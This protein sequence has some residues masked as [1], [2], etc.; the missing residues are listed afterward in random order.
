MKLKIVMLLSRI[1]QTGMTTHTLDLTKGLVQEGNEVFVISG[2]SPI[3]N[4][5]EL[6]KL[7]DRFFGSGAKI[8]EFKIPEG[9]LF[10]KSLN[11]ILSI[12]YIQLQL[13]KINPHIIHV[14]SPYM[15]FIPWFLNKKFLS[16]L[17]VTDLVKTF[18]YKNATHLIAISE[19]TK[20][21][22]MELY[23]YKERN[24]SKVLHG[25]SKNFS[26]QMDEKERDEF[27]INAK[28]PLDKIIIGMVASIEKRKGHDVLLKAIQLLS[29]EQKDEIHIVLLGSSKN[30]RTNEWLK[31]VIKLTDTAS[32]ITRFNYQYPNKFYDIMDI[33][34][35]P[36]RLEG[37]PL[38]V[39][40][41]MMS[42]CCVVR[43]N[44]EGAKDSIENGIDGFIFENEDVIAL[45]EIL[46]KLIVNE[47]ERKNV[48]RNG[49]IKA[50][51][52][53]SIESMTKNTTKVY[54]KIL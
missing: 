49:Q 52:C 24:I 36:S 1:D 8:V 42:N 18:K 13:L 19:E 41:A 31:N 15:S 16:T 29:D 39:L 34:V 40:E 28:I 3:E 33:F 45:S 23:G 12:L 20:K 26:I 9:N 10:I 53:F 54:E 4:N 27:K 51:N 2:A 50:L 17:H 7:K 14:Q 46:K 30:G 22:A 43:S 11:S 38:V 21:Y 25:V 6:I 44:N 47:K 5:Q 32:L 35:L 48:A 37:F